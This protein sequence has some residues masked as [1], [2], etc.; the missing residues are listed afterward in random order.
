MGIVFRRGRLEDAP[1]LVALVEELGYPAGESDVRARLG[2]LL[3]EGDQEL[4]VAEE[5]AELL[6]WVH[7]QEFL[8]LASAPA[9]LVTGLVVTR[10]ARRRGIGRAL[11]ERAEDWARARG[12]SS[13]R[14]RSRTTRSEAHAFY[15]RLGFAAA[16][17][18]VQFRK[19]LGGG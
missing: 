14:L 7:V 15:R 3:A 17:Q 8:S 16:K 12:L 9:A 19:E 11:M 5:G 10:H 13:L 1:A 18:Q 6:G 4:I 2:R